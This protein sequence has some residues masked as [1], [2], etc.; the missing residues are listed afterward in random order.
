[1]A[2]AAAPTGGRESSPSHIYQTRLSCADCNF[3]A[4]TTEELTH[5]LHEGVCRV[6]VR[7][8]RPARVHNLENPELSSAQLPDG[9]SVPIVAWIGTP[10]DRLEDDLS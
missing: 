8:K 3:K 2:E 9:K 10:D 6:A 1:M 7:Q 5:H 4:T